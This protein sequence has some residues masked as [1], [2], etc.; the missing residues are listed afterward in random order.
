MEIASSVMEFP[1][2]GSLE[3]V[4]WVTPS[5]FQPSPVRLDNTV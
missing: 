5:N 4:S 2:L 3:I 1:A